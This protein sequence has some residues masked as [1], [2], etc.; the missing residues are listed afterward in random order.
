ML[1]KPKRLYRKNKKNTRLNKMKMNK[2]IRNKRKI[3]VFL[4]NLLHLWINIFDDY[5]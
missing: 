3:K 5:L 4:R 2:K 1:I